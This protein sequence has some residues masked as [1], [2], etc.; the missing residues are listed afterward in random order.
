M[1]AKQ[2]KNRRHAA[3]THTPQGLG[4]GG[5]DPP[6]SRRVRDAAGLVRDGV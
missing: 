5:Y 2:L 6:R 4:G 1:K 3:L